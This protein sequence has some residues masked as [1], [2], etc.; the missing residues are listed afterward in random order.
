MIKLVKRLGSVNRSGSYWK[1]TSSLRRCL[2]SSSLRFG[3]LRHGFSCLFWTRL[4]N[5]TTNCWCSHVPTDD[6]IL[7]IHLIRCKTWWKCTQIY[8]TAFRV[9]PE[10]TRWL[11]TMKRYDEAK[12]LINQAAEMNRKSVPERLLVVPDEL[13]KV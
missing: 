5:V 4:E 6:I 12:E 1:E 9:L 3:F 8:R 11:I 13:E 2:V 7:V 10:S